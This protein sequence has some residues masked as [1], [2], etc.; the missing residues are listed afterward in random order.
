[1]KIALTS[2]LFI[3][4]DISFNL[5]QIEHYSKLAKEQNADLICFGE[6]F[7]QGFDCLYWN[8]EKDKKMAISLDS[9]TI[10]QLCQLSLDLQI[11]LMLG[12]I[13][14]EDNHLYSSYALL[15][16]GNIFHL[17]RRISKGWKEYRIT[18]FHYWEGN[19]TDIFE[20][21]GK[22]CTVALCG[23]LWEY[24]ECFCLGE[25]ILFWPVYLNFSKENWSESLCKEYSEQAAKIP[26]HVLLINSLSQ[27]PDAFGGCY[28]FYQ[29]SVK[30]ALE[31]GQEGLL[32][33]EL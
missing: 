7:L 28:H 24:P 6:S 2:A 8:Y 31:Y 25:D 23:D 19:S 30:D 16:Q 27:N 10:K 5:S 29:G 32:L 1:M 26:A 18:D 33:I 13:E 17:Y 15:S 14:R 11:D 9:P 21:H 20:Y 3:N 22:K 4:K 12:F